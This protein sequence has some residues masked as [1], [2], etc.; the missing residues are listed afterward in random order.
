MPL[1]FSTGW[2]TCDTVGNRVLHVPSDRSTLYT[3]TRSRL[4][5]MSCTDKQ[6]GPAPKAVDLTRKVTGAKENAEISLTC[7]HTQP[8]LLP[9]EGHS[10]AMR[11]CD[12]R[13]KPPKQHAQ[14][15]TSRAS[16]S[17]SPLHTCTNIACCTTRARIAPYA[18]RHPRRRWQNNIPDILSQDSP[19]MVRESELSLWANAKA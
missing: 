14:T 4:F 19:A 17:S 1:E 11:T 2:S 13:G 8:H 16:Q 6:D 12:I 5:R 15:Q 7:T 10:L 18:L 9:P 3:Y